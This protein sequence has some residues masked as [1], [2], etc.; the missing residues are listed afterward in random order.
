MD[1]AG[2]PEPAEARELQADPQPVPVPLSDDPDATGAV[3][4]QEG[5]L[6]L[7]CRRRLR[8]HAMHVVGEGHVDFE[9]FVDETDRANPLVV[10]HGNVR[11]LRQP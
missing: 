10:I 1:G 5:D 8:V 3:I 2:A 4:D 6:T 7:L 9:L 11:V